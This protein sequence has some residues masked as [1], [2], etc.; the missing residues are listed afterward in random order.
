MKRLFRKINSEYL[1]LIYHFKNYLSVSIFTKF[2]A[3]ISIPIFTRLLGPEGYGGTS[4]FL[5]I[6][7]I[8]SIFAAMGLDSS[9][10]RYYFEAGNNK[11]QFISSNIIVVFVFNSLLILFVLAFQDKLAD[12]VEIPNTLLILGFLVGIMHAYKSIIFG[13]WQASR[14]SGQISKVSIAN[15]TITI[16]VSIILVLI[17]NDY[18]GQVYGYLISALL[19]N[20][21]LLNKVKNL[22]IIHFD[23][24]LIKYSLVI[25]IPLVFN[26]VAGYVLV[27][28]DRLVINK[29]Y[30]MNETGIYSFAY[31]VAMIMEMIIFA[32]NSAWL[33]IFF[34]KMNEN[35]I[36]S[37]NPYFKVFSK[38]IF[39]SALALISFSSELLMILA[40]DRYNT[41]L[42]IVPVIILGYVFKFLY[43]FFS[44]VEYFYK[45]TIALA[46]FSILAGV[47]NIVLNLIY[48]PLYGGIGAAYTTLISYVLLFLLHFLYVDKVLKVKVFRIQI[49]LIPLIQFVIGLLLI[50]TVSGIIDN[51]VLVFV[52][53]IGVIIILASVYFY[54][55]YFRT[56]SNYKG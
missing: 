53:K 11:K 1:E 29:Y 14:F 22:F 19:I 34:K 46:F 49:L 33:P 47:V 50:D 2:L 39:L 38:I 24:K 15:G 40:D 21:F 30:G 43:S 44:N 55:N 13:L 37:L 25:G 9:I 10:K 42:S 28:F 5:S 35:G 51:Y 4:M 36:E 32:L 8:V 31:N 20:L 18:Y 12:I 16:V 26:Q 48:V 3:F 23:K 41:A 27:F 45:K 7:S 6:V 54:G 52:V 56:K 17:L